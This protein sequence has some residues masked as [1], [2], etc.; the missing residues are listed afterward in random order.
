MH[1]S[2]KRPPMSELEQTAERLRSSTSFPVCPQQLDIRQ[3]DWH[4]GSVAK[5]L[6]HRKKELP[7]TS[8]AP[9]PARHRSLRMPDRIYAETFTTTICHPSA[10]PAFSTTEN[11]A[12]LRPTSRRS[13]ILIG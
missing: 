8:R 9:A 13:S 7:L 3:R 11:P 1:R 2:K 10:R 12:W 4:V 6:G 5:V